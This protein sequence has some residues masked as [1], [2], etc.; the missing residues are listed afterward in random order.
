MRLVARL[1]IGVAAVLFLTGA[2]LYLLRKPIAGAAVE[3]VMAGARLQNPSVE[4]TEVNFS[5]L[6][7]SRMTAGAGA[8]SPDL[9]LGPVVF[10]YDWRDLI[11]RRKLESVSID[12]GR[13]VAALSEKGVVTI[14]GWSP[15]PNAKPAPPP[16]GSLTVSGLDVIADMPKG[17]APFNVSGAFDLK[18]GGHFD[19]VIEAD[20]TGFTSAALSRVSGGAAIDLGADGAI[21]LAAALKGDLATPAGVATDV[22]ATL[23][24]AL[25]SWRGFFGDGPRGLKGGAGVAIKS[26]TIDAE[27]AAALSPL[28]STGGVPI[29]KMA[30]SGMFKASFDA[31]AVSVSLADHPLTIAAD[32]GDRAIISDGDGP[33]YERR[34]GEE[35]LALKAAIE[36]PVANG[37]ASINAVSVNKG[38]WSIDA[39][40]KAG[41]QSIGGVSLS[42]FDG[43]FRGAYSDDRADGEAVI[44]T[45][46]KKATIGR[47]AV[48]DMPA[49]GRLAVNVDVAGKLLTVSPSDGE[50]LN[51]DR[52]NFRFAE[53]DMDARIAAA[54]LCQASAPLISIGWGEKAATHVEGVLTA[55]TAHYRLGKTVFNG[56]PPRV[57]FTLDYAPALQK[58][59]I[60]GVLAGGKVVLNNML[61][62][63][64]AKG[65]FDADLVR[66][67]VAANIALSSMRITQKAELEKVAPVMVTGRAQLADNVATFD[68]DV[69]TPQGAPLGKGEGVHQVATGRGEA[70]FDSGLLKFSYAFQPDRLIPALRGVISNASGMTEGRARFSWALDEIA[71]SATVNLDNVS[72]GGPGVA[73]TR[74]EGVTGKLVFSGLSPVA[75]AGEQSISIRKIDLDALKLENGSAR[76]S[77]PGDDTLEIIEAEFPWFSGTIGAYGSKLSIAGGKSEAALQIDNV[78]LGELLSYLNVEGLS[79][80]GVIEGVL[81]ISFE[82]SRARV[83]NGI[84]SSKGSGVVRYQGKASAAAAQSNEQSALA[85]EIL[86][87]LRFEKLSATV[88]GPLDGTLNFKIYFEGRSDIPV[89]TGRKTQ[90]VD[91]PVN[92]R[93]N[94][95]APLLSLIEQAVLS[96]DVK[97]QIERAKQEEAAKKQS[98]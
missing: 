97:L 81:P 48:T 23:D 41:E 78:D 6:T 57:D 82:G 18:D 56:A 38:P 4:V 65:D 59:R 54:S 51:T 68:F 69:K 24:A 19:V 91:S 76:F 77:L 36:G 31:D 37:A 29:R 86:R 92:Y 39:S 58:S 67:T 15:D 35:R 40:A 16:F 3:R 32:R 73:V 12:G 21:A 53:Q 63:T 89:K 7:L 8:A 30:L 42:S 70:I 55:R 88:D 52:A 83:N 26:S 34:G 1:I 47:L 10:G 84:L 50:C 98:Q 64:E 80:V 45:H 28:T 17:P 71:S 94:I 33:V 90:R 49:A 13:L 96:T 87:E 60:V 66:D 20:G 22:D 44:V 43:T 2:G 27:S 62:L 14:A 46:I 85:F 79:G 61:I 11:F 72:F 5:R 74:T 93:I 75:T 95:E 9:S 25:S